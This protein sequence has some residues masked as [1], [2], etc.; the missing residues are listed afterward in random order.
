MAELLGV[1]AGGAGLAS[2]A[3][4]LVDSA[5]K[6]RSFCRASKNASQSINDLIFDIE[7]LSL[8]LRH[9]ERHQAR[10][11]NADSVLLERCVVACRSKAAQISDLVARMELKMRNFDKLGKLYVAFKEPEVKK[12]VDDMERAKSSIHFAYIMYCQSLSMRESESRAAI[13]A[14]HHDQ[15]ATHT[16]QLDQIYNSGTLV[17]QQIALLVSTAASTPRSADVRLSPDDRQDDQQPQNVTKSGPV[18]SRISRRQNKTLWR[19]RL[20]LPFRAWAWDIAVEVGGSLTVHVRPFNI[21]PRGCAPFLLL[22]RGD[23]EA[24]RGCLANRQ[25]SVWDRD[26]QG[27]SML[28]YAAESLNMDLLTMLLREDPNLHDSW[29]MDHLF[30]G[31]GY[32]YALRYGQIQATILRDLLLLCI[33]HGMDVNFGTW[34]FAHLFRA[35]LPGTFMFRASN[36]LV[37]DECVDA[38]LRNQYPPIETLSFERRFNLAM[39]SDWGPSRFLSFITHHGNM[40]VSCVSFS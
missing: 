39:R 8:S 9:L 26:E 4:Q 3:V 6:L 24:V 25:L 23:L 5:E 22:E 34:T 31:G 11:N 1:V 36:R 7:T 33:K 2:L 30:A 37:L 28:Q 15:L 13:A 35:T 38:I 17:S 14:S 27:R 19:L 16:R 20:A 21:R 18:T 12:L 29:N 32:Q 10:G 40:E